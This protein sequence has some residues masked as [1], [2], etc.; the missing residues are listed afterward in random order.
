MKPNDYIHSQGLKFEHS[1]SFGYCSISVLEFLWGRTW[2]ETVLAYIGA[3]NPSYLRVVL[4]EETL[5]GLLGRVTV[6]INENMIIK[7]IKQEVK[8]DLPEGV[9]NA[10]ELGKRV[11]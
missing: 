3:I 5:D 11:K 9:E 8:V 4:G 10:Y 6:H 1:N 2:D 7:D